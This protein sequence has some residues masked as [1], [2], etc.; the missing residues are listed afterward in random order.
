MFLH[1]SVRDFVWLAPLFPPLLKEPL[2]VGVVRAGPQGGGTAAVVRLVHGLD[3]LLGHHVVK[4]AVLLEKSDLE[5]V[6]FIHTGY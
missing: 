2:L 4:G 6:T 3:T 1:P 5:H